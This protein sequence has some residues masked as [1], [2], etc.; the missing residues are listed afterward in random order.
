[1]AVFPKESQMIALLALLV[2]VT[3]VRCSDGER[4]ERGDRQTP[5]AQPSTALRETCHAMYPQQPDLEQECLKRWT[6]GDS[7]S[8]PSTPP[9]GTGLTPQEI[10][11]NCAALAQLDPRGV[12]SAHQLHEL[13]ACVDRWSPVLQGVR[14]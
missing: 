13:T 12:L 8:G 14:R 3:M 11:A 9:R 6:V 10:I 2:L 1:M 7:I 4:R 5:V